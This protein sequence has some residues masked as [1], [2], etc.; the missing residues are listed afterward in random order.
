MK[1]NVQHV[2]DSMISLRGAD[3]IHVCYS[4]VGRGEG[5]I[6]S[7]SHSDTHVLLIAT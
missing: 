5:V 7:Y 4:F 6:H 2:S 3:T 1:F